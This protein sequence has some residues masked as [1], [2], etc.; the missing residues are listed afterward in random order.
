MK[1]LTARQAAEELSHRIH[2][3]LGL[4]VFF[5]AKPTRLFSLEIS[6]I[7]RLISIVVETEKNSDRGNFPLKSKTKKFD[8]LAVGLR[9]SK[10]IFC[11]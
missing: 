8:G 1:P 3:S 10:E 9:P 6:K 4:T 5:S 11:A 2:P 7:G